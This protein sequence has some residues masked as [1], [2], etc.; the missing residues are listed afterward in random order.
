LPLRPSGPPTSRGECSAAARC[1]R[2]GASPRCCLTIRAAAAKPSMP[3]ASATRRAAT[4]SRA[5][6]HTAS[7]S[8]SGARPTRSLS[9]ASSPS[10]GPGAATL[11]GL[12]QGARPPRVCAPG[13]RFCRLFSEGKSERLT[14][15]PSTSSLSIALSSDRSASNFFS[16]P[17][18]VSS[19][20]SRLTVSSSA[21]PY[22]YRHRR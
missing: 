4:A 15:F 16:H 7:V 6:G 5:A 11:R 1:G 3:S 12:P 2:P 17:F 21:P 22:S 8:V 14:S 13:L 18:S 9:A 20:L 10:R 19:S